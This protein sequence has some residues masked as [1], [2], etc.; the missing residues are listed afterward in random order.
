MYIFPCYKNVIFYPLGCLS[1]V[2]D[3][4]VLCEVAKDVPLWPKGRPVCT[5]TNG[6]MTLWLTSSAGHSHVIKIRVLNF[7]QIKDMVVICRWQF[8]KRSLPSWFL[9]LFKTQAAECSWFRP[10]ALC[11]PTHHTMPIFQILQM[12]FLAV[13]KRRFHGPWNNRYSHLVIHTHT[14]QPCEFLVVQMNCTHKPGEL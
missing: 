1:G 10:P 7:T 2:A 6:L 13:T 4:L 11:R 14:C 12:I 5:L 8:C 3:C 9:N